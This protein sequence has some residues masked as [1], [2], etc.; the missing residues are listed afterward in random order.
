MDRVGSSQVDM[1]P[2]AAHKMLSDFITAWAVSQK[3]ASA[4]AVL[5]EPFSTELGPDDMDEL[6]REMQDVHYWRD[7]QRRPPQKPRMNENL[8]GEAGKHVVVVHLRWPVEAG[9]RSRVQSDLLHE[10]GLLEDH[11]TEAL[12][13][14][15]VGGFDC[16]EIDLDE[17][18]IFMYGPDA[19][20]LFATVEGILRESPVTRGGWVIKL[21]GDPFDPNA[22]GVRVE[23]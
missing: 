1:E 20:R 2:E 5:S 6:E 18:Q 10:Y 22:Q 4:R 16:S 7:S 13:T 12:E 9:G 11:L 23:L 19:D 17:Y 3:L 15:G 14:A 8:E 21:Y